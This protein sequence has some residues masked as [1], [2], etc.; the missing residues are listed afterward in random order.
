MQHDRD[1]RW[2]WA[3]AGNGITNVG[4]RDRPVDGRRL[5]PGRE[6]LGAPVYAHL[7]VMVEPEETDGEGQEAHHCYLLVNLASSQNRDREGKVRARSSTRAH[8]I[9]AGLGACL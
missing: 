8:A 4:W 5:S 1:A 9:T 3:G 2:R 7:C 6:A